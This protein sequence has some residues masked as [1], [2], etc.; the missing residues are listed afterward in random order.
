[1]VGLFEVH[2]LRRCRTPIKSKSRGTDVVEYVM[3]EFSYAS[4][5]DVILDW[6]KGMKHKVGAWIRGS[7][8]SH[9]HNVCLHYRFIISFI[10]SFERR[11]TR[12]RNILNLYKFVIF[13]G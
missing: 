4:K 5:L 10:I 8:T 9:S 1:M 11:E 6:W 12:L 7:I 2:I 3:S 13:M